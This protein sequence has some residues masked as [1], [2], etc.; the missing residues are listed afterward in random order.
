VAARKASRYDTQDSRLQ[1]HV[2]VIALH[3]GHKQ[4]AASRL[5]HA[6][7]LNPQF[8]PVYADDARRLL[9]QI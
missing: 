5:R 6:L 3:N 9:A 7:A 4:E 1:Y 2:G 8:H